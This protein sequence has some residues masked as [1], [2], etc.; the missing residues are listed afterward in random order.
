MWY[1]AK[2]KNLILKELDFLKKGNQNNSNLK[3][4][5]LDSIQDLE[6]NTK[7]ILEK[8]ESLNKDV[9][10]GCEGF[11]SF[12]PFYDDIFKIQAESILDKLD[13]R[14]KNYIK[15][16]HNSIKG[17]I[18][19]P[20]SDNDD[21]PEIVYPK[22]KEIY[23]AQGYQS[24]VYNKREHRK[25][26]LT[27]FDF[28]RIS[29]KGEDVGKLLLEVLVNPNS[30][31]KP[32]VILGNPGAGKSMFSKVFTAKLCDTT[33]YIP[34]LIRLRDVASSSSNISE[35]INKG[36][37][38]TIGLQE[39]NWI[40]W[41][42]LFKTRI[43]VILLDGFDEL[44]QSSSIELN[45]YIN[46]I[47]ALQETAIHNDICLKV[48]L[49]SRIAVMQDVSIP[50][51]TFILKL[52][53]FDNQ[54]KNLWI[55]KWNSFQTK[56]KY[57]FNLPNDRKISELS[58]EPLL[59]FMLAV[60]DFPSSDLQKITSND[61]FNQSKLYDSLLNSFGLRQLEKED[62]Y[63]NGNSEHKKK[64]EEMFRLRLGLISL[65]MFL[66]D[67]T[68]KDISRLD[69]ELKVCKLDSSKIKPIDVLT[70]FFFVH[71]NKSTSENDIESYNYEFLHKSFGEF[72]AADFLLRIAFKQ[73]DRQNKDIE[74]FR[75]CFGYNWLH[76]HPEIQRF[77]FEHAPHVFDPNRNDQERIIEAIQ[78]ALEGLFDK[79]IND[80]PISRFTIIPPK[81][82]IEHIAIYSQNLIFLWL[83]LSEPNKKIDFDIISASSS[84]QL[85]STKGSEEVFNFSSQDRDETV[86]S[87]LH[88]KRITH[89]WQ[90][91]GN[92]H[93][94]AKLN[95]WVNV[96]EDE[97]I[98][99]VK[100]KKRREI[101]N[102]FSESALVSCNDFNFLM[103]LFDIENKYDYRELLNKIN[104]IIKQKPEFKNLCNEVILFRLSDW[105]LKE[106]GGLQDIFNY[107]L[108]ADLSPKQYQLLVEKFISLSGFISDSDCAYIGER[109]F[110]NIYDLR[111]LSGYNL[112]L[113]KHLSKFQFIPPVDKVFS[114]RDDI[115]ERIIIDNLREVNEANSFVIFR[116]V[117]EI[118]LNSR[119][120][121]H[122]HYKLFDEIIHNLR[123]TVGKNPSTD[124]EY[125]K[126]LKNLGEQRLLREST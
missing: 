15:A 89:L 106:Q 57:Q 32:I 110:K 78:D 65:L 114:H 99:L 72:L 18:D 45:G 61:S 41:A 112:L 43:P 34:F 102:N 52:N 11:S 116:N 118:I 69:E 115:I 49:T 92:N 81:S 97:K 31:L 122:F 82:K 12:E 58:Q 39:I 88:W 36:I 93:S 60:Y 107:L 10:L 40:E 6:S 42:K 103:S 50:D 101:K 20:L 91:V 117:N 120:Q 87:K 17:E 24:V 84:T 104:S 44:M 54:R 2:Q 66:T 28:D 77:L 33:D 85:G 113:L 68:N 37:A 46:S 83:A 86:Q 98:T 64:E 48:I 3:L 59:L 53:T 119:I 7:I 38:K 90:L 9:F 123:Y 19:K 23:I 35:H 22:N 62:E 80:L 30:N 67:S 124:I 73:K 5:I 27:A 51:G 105:T 4:E 95:E 1:D 75:F 109:I 76:K 16:H 8:V 94:V 21:I 71:Q 121:I 14:T 108:K 70:G 13:E 26:F 125:I 47:K 63:L 79:S 100:R 56:N 126:L 96:S 74:L 29:K 111:G 55:N 25:L